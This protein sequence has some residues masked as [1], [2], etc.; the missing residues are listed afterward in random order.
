MED[1]HIYNCVGELVKAKV[2]HQSSTELAINISDL[3][4]GIYFVE[5]KT[6]NEIAQKK[7][8]KN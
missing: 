2:I 3:A 5:V 1:I 6:T 7:F 8:I 4:K